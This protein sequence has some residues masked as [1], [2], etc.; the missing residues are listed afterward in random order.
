MRDIA[1]ATCCVGELIWRGLIVV[2]CGLV[3][4]ASGKSEDQFSLISMVRLKG[5][6]FM[7]DTCGDSRQALSGVA[8]MEKTP[9]PGADDASNMVS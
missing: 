7:Y 1:G 4:S 9:E 5:E 2:T 8:R 6:S 3:S